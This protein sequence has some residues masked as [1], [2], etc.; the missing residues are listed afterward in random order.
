[1]AL[2][3]G[4]VGLGIMGQPMAQNVVKGGYALSVYN[5]SSEK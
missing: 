1:M 4:F 2:K 5:R 3:V